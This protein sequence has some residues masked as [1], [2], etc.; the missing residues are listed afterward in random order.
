VKLHI[1]EEGAQEGVVPAAA[2]CLVNATRVCQN[3]ILHEL[4]IATLRLQS[5]NDTGHVLAV[6]VVDDEGTRNI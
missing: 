2:I 1:K 4:K 3:V 6:R 5:F